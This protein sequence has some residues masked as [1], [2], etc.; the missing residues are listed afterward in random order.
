MKKK[1]QKLLKPSIAILAMFVLINLMVVPALAKEDNILFGFTI[2]AHNENTF[3]VGRDRTTK[4]AETPWMV[5]L[6][7]SDEDP[8]VKC[9]TTFWLSK[10]AKELPGADGYSRQSDKHTIKEGSGKH[11]YTDAYLSACNETVYLTAENNNDT[12]TS[13][14]AIGYWDEEYTK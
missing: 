1:I 3:S 4:N 14:T 7:Q 10:K 13:Y 11:K 2:L 5:N 6:T 9:Q 8:G 12:A